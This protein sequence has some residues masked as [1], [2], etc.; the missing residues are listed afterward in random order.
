MESSKR[1]DPAG[2]R[3]AGGRLVSQPP[4][5]PSPSCPTPLFLKIPSATFWSATPFGPRTHVSESGDLDELPDIGSDELSDAGLEEL[6]DVDL[7]S[8]GSDGL[9]EL[10]DVALESPGSRCFFQNIRKNTVES[11]SRNLH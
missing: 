7:E 4:S 2:T 9:G 11:R 5:P 10:P 6:P 8:P 1:P 3:A